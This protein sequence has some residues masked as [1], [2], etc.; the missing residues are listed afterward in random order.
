MGIPRW[1][2]LQQ[3]TDDDLIDRYNSAAQN[4]VVG[5]GFYRDELHRRALERESVRMTKLTT[6]GRHYSSG[7]MP[8]RLWPLARTSLRESAFGKTLIQQLLTHHCGELK[9]E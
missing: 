3:L 1:E 2:Q 7:R 5:T 8:C 9:P 4:T 6:P